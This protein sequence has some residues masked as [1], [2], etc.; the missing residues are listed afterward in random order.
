MPA[1]PTSRLT[2]TSTRW[3]SPRRAATPARSSPTSPPRTAPT[4]RPTN[5]VINGCPDDLVP[6]TDDDF[7]AEENNCAGG[8]TEVQD[9]VA[10]FAFFMR[11]LAP[12]AA[13]HR[14]QQRPRPH[15]VQPRGLQR[16]PPEHDL[17]VTANGRSHVVPAVLRLP[18][19]RHG[20]AGRRHRQRRRLGGGHPPHEDGAAVGPPLPQ[21]AAARRAHLDKRASAIQA[22]DGQGAAARNA[23]NAR[24]RGA[25]ER[26][27]A[28]PEL[29]LALQ[30]TSPEGRR[31]RRGT[32]PFLLFADQA[33]RTRPS[34]GSVAPGQTRR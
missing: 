34:E 33:S 5:A 16:L 25:A 27:A 8:L 3:A 15:G 24:H 22:H 13:R 14:Q 31:P 12:A 23:F 18:R 28:V 6:G 21:P 17:H 1:W 2:P 20:G 9:D 32:P 26:P 30:G 19:A 10:N 7:A 29:A 4:A 11:N